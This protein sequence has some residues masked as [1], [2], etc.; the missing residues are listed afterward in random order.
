[1]GMKLDFIWAP[2][3][4][5]LTN[6]GMEFKE[7]HVYPNL[8]VM[9]CGLWHMLHITNALDYGVELGILRNSVTSLLPWNLA[10]M[11]Q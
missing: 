11:G 8:L 1:M 4:T 6:L 10:L 3:A 7:N 9:G 2:Y 5:N